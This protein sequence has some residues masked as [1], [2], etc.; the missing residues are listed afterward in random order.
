MHKYSA[1]LLTS[2][3]PTILG[4]HC[5]KDDAGN[6]QKKTTAYVSEGSLERIE[7]E[8]PAGLID[9]F[10]NLKENQALCYGVAKNN[11]TK[12]LSQDRWLKSGKP[13]DCITRT[14][15]CIEW[16]S[17]GGILMLDY[18]PDE[19]ENLEIEVLLQRLFAAYPVLEEI[20]HITGY[21]SSSYLYDGEEQLSG[22]RGI[23]I[24]FLVSRAADIPLIGERI[25][26]KLWS[27]GYGKY[28]V[29]K[30]GQL[31]E[32]PLFDGSVHKPMGLD[33]AGGAICS[34]GIN[35]RRGNPN[36]IEGLFAPAIDINSDVPA[37][38]DEDITNANNFKLIARNLL[39]EDS[40]A[41]KA[42]FTE[43]RTT[44]LL[45][46]YPDL[47]RSEIDTTVRQAIES[48][49]LMGAWPIYLI[50]G[51]QQKEVS[52]AE[53]LDNPQIYH[54]A[55]TL[56]PLEPDY[57]NSGQVGIIYT[58]QQTPILYSQAHGGI[59]YKLTK[60]IE[61]IE[62]VFG[63]EYLATDGLI[64]A[65]DQNPNFYNF[66]S[67]LVKV[68][69]QGQQLPLNPDS[70]RYSLGGIVQFWSSKIVRDER[71]AILENPRP[72]LCKSILALRDTRKIKSLTSIIT[73]PTL[74]PDGSVLRNPGYDPET[75][76]LFIPTTTTPIIE[77]APTV[78]Q[79][80]GALEQL[81]KPFKDFPFVDNLDRTVLLCALLT[82]AIRP[83]LPTAPAF[84]IDAPVQASG[85]TLLA[86]CLGVIATGKEPG[87]WPH[88]SGRDDEE[89]RKRLFTAL[90]AGNLAIIWDNVVGVFDSVAMSSLLTSSIYTDRILSTS[91][92]S[93][94]PNRLLLVLTGNN[95]TLKGDL[96]RRVPICRID[97]ETDK[98]FA[99]AFDL[100][101][102]AYCLENRQL[103]VASAITLI[104][105]YLS[106]ATAPLGKGRM[107]SFEAWDDFV[108]QTVLYLNQTI[109]PNQFGDVM[110]KITLNQAADPEHEAM[111]TILTL[112]WNKYGDNSITASE[113]LK[114]ITL[115]YKLEELNVSAYSDDARAMSDAFE[116]LSPGSK[117]STIT[118]GRILGYRKDRIVGGMRLVQCGSRNKTALWKVES[119][120]EDKS[121]S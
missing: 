112:W 28:K 47:D 15:R 83:A 115:Q 76:L 93:S 43:D 87:I 118:L 17:D 88:T 81:W 105:F 56:D 48:K 6:F 25:N 29:S 86:Q 11:A 69:E 54:E 74:R 102:Y 99:R 30:A 34:N 16:G 18:D 7:F 80:T 68:N 106:S 73:A 20:S 37:L 51:K 53:I 46:K 114:Y 5:F 35:Q 19:K 67:E 63:K 116:D 66:G 38:S 3:Y 77:D 121:C 26:E 14:D 4:K 36:L 59:S 23:R 27:L 10:V 107:A 97:P 1:S 120:A 12:L 52:V 40:R 55:A 103:L 49:T 60:N 58:L 33:F 113:L 119:I 109:A 50:D 111:L 94:V 85:K 21:S 39:L 95:L 110:E 64:A 45:K 2:T 104:R 70:L 72:G 100:D 75:R 42:K 61:L 117:R 62:V 13:S 9:I 89:V 79:A 32:K 84:G 96:V 90:L 101:P 31:L 41:T 57:N 22:S 98:P 71:K 91:H 78:A 24:Y 82:A 108:R 44:S 8:D 65:L 92:S